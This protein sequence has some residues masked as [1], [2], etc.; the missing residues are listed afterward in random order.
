MRHG[1]GCC[2]RASAVAVLDDREDYGAEPWIAVGPLPGHAH[3]L[4]LVTWTEWEYRIHIISVRR[5]TQPK[6]AILSIVTA[7]PVNPLARLK[8]RLP[9]LPAPTPKDRARWK[10]IAE[11]SS[12]VIVSDEAPDVSKPVAGLIA[13]APPASFPIDD[14]TA[15]WFDA[16]GGKR[17]VQRALREYIRAHRKSTKPRGRRRPGGKVVAGG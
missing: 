12:P 7:A 9:P 17:A 14:R 8:A 10:R 13:C 16:N 15:A 3:A 4:L 11:D 6:G 5:T 2:E 1:E